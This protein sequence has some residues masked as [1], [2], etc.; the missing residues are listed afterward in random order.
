MTDAGG[1]GRLARP[2]VLRVT[3]GG[4]EALLLRIAS[5]VAHYDVRRFVLDARPDGSTRVRM[6]LGGTP[7]D[8]SAGLLERRLGR[9][10]GVT[11][12]VRTG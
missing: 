6:E 10:V 5:L 9:I 12:V 3:A 11:E 8:P 7:A 1:P 4:E 2:T